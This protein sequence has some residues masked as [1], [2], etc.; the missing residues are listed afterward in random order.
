MVLCIQIARSSSVL[1]FDE[2]EASGCIEMPE[3]NKKRDGSSK[4][5]ARS[6]K[7][8]LHIT[9]RLM[10]DVGCRMSDVRSSKIRV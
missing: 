8:T 2:G 5:E 10:L 4:R 9:L 1:T 6:L 3:C 7:L